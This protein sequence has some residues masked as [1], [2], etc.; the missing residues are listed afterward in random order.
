MYEWYWSLS[1][2]KIDKLELSTN[3]LQT[4]AVFKVAADTHQELVTK[5]IED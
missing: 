5:E 1:D 3:D 2:G 4:C